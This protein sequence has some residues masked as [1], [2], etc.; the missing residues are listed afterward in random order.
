MTNQAKQLEAMMLITN[1]VLETVQSAGPMG[2]PEGHLFAGLM[3]IP[4][5]RVEH[6]NMVLRVLEGAGRVTRSNFLVKA[7]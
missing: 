7:V 1:A 4:D 2:V 6:L 5:F 3:T